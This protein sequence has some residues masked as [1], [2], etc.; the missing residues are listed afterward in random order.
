MRASIKVPNDSLSRIQGST[1]LREAVLGEGRYRD[2]R[3]V[4]GR[5]WRFTCFAAV[6]DRAGDVKGSEEI[7]WHVSGDY[8]ACLAVKV[9]GACNKDGAPR[10]G[11]WPKALKWAVAR[12]A[13]RNET[14]REGLYVRDEAAR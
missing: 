10:L 14:R 4:F 13:L 8:C 3:G 11:Q 9:P 5:S 1:M 12:S 2:R 6:T 7:V